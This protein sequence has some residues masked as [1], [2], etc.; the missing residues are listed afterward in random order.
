MFHHM[1]GNLGS[2]IERGSNLSDPAFNVDS[3]LDYTAAQS[4][5]YTVCAL[6]EL[7]W[8]LFATFPDDFIA[9]AP[10]LLLVLLNPTLQFLKAPPQRFT[11][12]NDTLSQTLPILSCRQVFLIRMRSS[13]S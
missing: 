9:E 11:K 3:R 2:L 6:I 7:G 13:L 4:S 5:V 12:S 8:N 10:N 1:R